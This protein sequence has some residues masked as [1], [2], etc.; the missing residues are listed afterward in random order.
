MVFKYF[1]NIPSFA[2]KPTLSDCNLRDAKIEM[3]ERWRS[4]VKLIFLR[5][6]RQIPDI[7]N[8][9]CGRPPMRMLTRNDYFSLKKVTMSALCPRHFGTVST[10]LS[11]RSTIR[12]TFWLSFRSSFC[13]SCPR[14]TMKQ[15]V[16]KPWGTETVKI[17]SI[18]MTYNVWVI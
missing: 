15:K 13:P 18:Y 10:W 6:V 16:F 17:R 4:R 1:T 8:E 5:T 7:L 12:L 11:S 14:R 3:N 9:K 2:F